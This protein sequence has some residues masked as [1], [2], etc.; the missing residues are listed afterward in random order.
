MLRVK[1]GQKTIDYTLSD[2]DEIGENSYLL[3]TDG[4]AAL[5]FGTMYTV[6][7]ITLDGGENVVQTL[8]YGINSY[9]YSVQNDPDMAELAQRTYLYGVSAK[10]YT[11]AK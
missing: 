10:A 9:V 8:E 5:D 1:N 7:L 4:I 2:F 3:M 11:D 6:E